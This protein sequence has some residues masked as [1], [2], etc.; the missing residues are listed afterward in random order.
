MARK[1]RE[2]P[3]T[4]A[5]EPA[6]MATARMTNRKREAEERDSRQAILSAVE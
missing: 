3:R 1:E 4:P 2:K 6:P 5:S